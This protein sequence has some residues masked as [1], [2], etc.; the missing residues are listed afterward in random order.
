MSNYLNRRDFLKRNLIVV[1]SLFLAQTFSSLIR[2]NRFNQSEK[3]NA[4]TKEAK[5]YKNLAG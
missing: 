4:S 1:C 3:V 5:Y 2:D